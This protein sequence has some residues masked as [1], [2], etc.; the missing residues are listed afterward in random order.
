MEGAFHTD[1]STPWELTHLPRALHMTSQASTSWYVA[2]SSSSLPRISS[3]PFPLI[4]HF[5]LPRDITENRD[6]LL[7]QLS[8]EPKHF[9]HKLPNRTSY[10]WGET[11]G[12]VLSGSWPWVPWAC[13]SSRDTLSTDSEDGDNET[14]SSPAPPLHFSHLE[15][16]CDIS[17]NGI[18]LM[19]RLNGTGILIFDRF[20]LAKPDPFDI[21]NLITASQSWTT[22]CSQ[23]PW[24]AI[25]YFSNWVS[26]PPQQVPNTLGELTILQ[27]LS[28][29]PKGEGRMPTFHGN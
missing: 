23:L 16:L 2:H 29:W 6:S 5:L 15:L 28:W 17:A 1:L 25:S 13:K 19:I 9:Q 26:A 7:F 27:P 4:S 3:P 22:S 12:L 14:C 8:K 18:I 21:I 20:W 11:K 24:R 10:L